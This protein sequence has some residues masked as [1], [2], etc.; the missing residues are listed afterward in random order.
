MTSEFRIPAPLQNTIDNLAFL[1][2]TEDGEKLFF[3]EKVHITSSNWAARARRFYYNENLESQKK[4]IKE[5]I[6]LGLDSLK[7]YTGNVHYSRLVTEFCKARDG[8]LNL[9]NTYL[10]QGVATT[11]LDTYIYIMENQ[12][13]ALKDEGFVGSNGAGTGAAQPERP[14]VRQPPTQ[15]GP[16]GQ[17]AVRTQPALI[18]D[19]AST[20]S[21]AISIP[22]Q[23]A[24]ARAMGYG[25]SKLVVNQPNNGNKGNKDNY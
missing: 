24:R 14:V 2:A 19:A 18:P 3:K 5:I 11:D 23:S 21:V 1:A 12:I 8:L 20:G 16:P 15:P 9:R 22:A 4:I 7:S 17:P 25:G 13:Q 6:D 10:K